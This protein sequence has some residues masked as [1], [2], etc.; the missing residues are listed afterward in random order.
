MNS[1]PNSHLRPYQEV[2]PLPG[3]RLIG[4]ILRLIGWF[5]P[6]LAAR[7]LLFFFSITGRKAVHFRED[8]LL[9]ETRRGR[10]ES[11]GHRI[12]TY[13]WGESERRILLTHGWQSRGTALRYFVPI[14]LS[15][16]FQ[17]VALD[18]PG[19]GESSGFR[20][21][22]PG[23]AEAI[24]EVDRVLGPFEGAITHSFGGRALTYALG[25]LAHD[26]KLRRIVML[27]APMSLSG[28]FME[29]FERLGIPEAIREATRR[30]GRHVL[31]RP[32][33]E[34]EIYNLGSRLQADL[35]LIHDT[36]DEV[37]PLDEARRIHTSLPGSR[38]H[39]TEGF[40]HYRQ[41]KA[42]EIWLMAADFLEGKSVV[43]S[44]EKS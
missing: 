29:F 44:E 2:K 23:Y 25:F 9:Q 19:H 37:V 30:R 42:P 3:L 33:E 14:L 41:A 32:I 18:A 20:M 24:R 6:D 12:R 5:S 21:V 34:S 35:L 8:R 1:H 15:R 16:G 38:L 31:R 36:Q 22:L 28:I 4:S 43:T 11:G 17:V 13:T 7:T 10:V 27:S 40:G 39:V 26:W